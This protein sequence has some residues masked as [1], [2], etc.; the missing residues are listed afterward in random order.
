MP[1]DLS[2]LPERDVRQYIERFAAAHQVTLE[3]T[4]LDDWA[5]AVT[6][7]AGDDVVLDSTEK[8]LVALKKQGLISA[9]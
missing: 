5:E 1:G 8:L 3:R 6:R 2:L 7:A 9:R 4:R